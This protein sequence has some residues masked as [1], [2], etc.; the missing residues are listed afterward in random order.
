MQELDSVYFTVSKSSVGRGRG[1]ADKGV[2]LLFYT[3]ADSI[4]EQEK[5]LIALKMHFIYDVCWSETDFTRKQK[6]TI[7]SVH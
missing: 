4:Y 3:L 5:A 7:K 6:W 2:N 1:E